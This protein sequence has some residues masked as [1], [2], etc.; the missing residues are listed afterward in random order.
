MEG[1][2]PLPNQPPPLQGE[3]LNQPYDLL[4]KEG[5]SK[6]QV[7]FARRIPQPPH[8]LLTVMRGLNLLPKPL[9]PLQGRGLTRK[10]QKPTTS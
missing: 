9:S 1:A 7:S 6:H 10:S 5:A 4:R 8:P 3:I 2:S